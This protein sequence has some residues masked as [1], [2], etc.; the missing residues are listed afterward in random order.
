[1]AARGATALALGVLLPGPAAAGSL[2]ISVSP[3]VALRDGSLAA[4]VQVATSGAE[5][6]HAVTPALH[7][8]DQD[9]GAT[10]RETLAPKE[11]MAAQLTLPVGELGNGR[12]PY[13]V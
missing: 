1:M 7:F 3:T 10:P 13:R 6:A 9:A 4:T 8:R 12:W 2:S 11:S 5:A